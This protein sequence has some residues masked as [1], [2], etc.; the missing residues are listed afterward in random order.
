MNIM[1]IY[2]PFQPW[3]SSKGWRGKAKAI[4]DIYTVPWKDAKV[5]TCKA[6][7]KKNKSY[8]SGSR[9]SSTVPCTPIMY[10]ES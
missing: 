10:V 9:E 4:K 7:Q 6:N 5:N 3:E 8:L 1:P 2:A